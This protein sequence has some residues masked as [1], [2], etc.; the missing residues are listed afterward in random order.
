MRVNQQLLVLFYFTDEIDGDISLFM[1]T[2]NLRLE[3]QVE[4]DLFK[5]KTFEVEVIS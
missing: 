3:V 4:V 2:N 1:Y 5:F